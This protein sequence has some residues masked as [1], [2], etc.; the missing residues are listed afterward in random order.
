MRKQ[1]LDLEGQWQRAPEN[2]VADSDCAECGM[3]TW[4]REYHPL[5]ACALYKA[6]RASEHVR[7]MLYSVIEFARRRN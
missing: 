6:M 7:T 1:Y 2:G 3:G 4:S 5:A